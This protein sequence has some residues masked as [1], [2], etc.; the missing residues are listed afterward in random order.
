[1][2]RSHFGLKITLLVLALLSPYV[3]P[4]NLAP[5]VANAAPALTQVT[6]GTVTGFPHQGDTW[7]TTWS[8][9]GNLYTTTDDGNGFGNCQSNV[10]VNRLTG[11]SPSNLTG[12]SVNCMSDY[13]HV[14]DGQQHCDGPGA[15]GQCVGRTWKVGGITS[16]SNVLYLSITRDANMDSYSPPQRQDSQNATIIKSTDHGVTWSGSDTN[17]FNNP[18]FPGHNHFSKPVFIEYGQNGT[19]TADGADTYVYAISNDGYW[20]NGS[21]MYLGRVLR[22]KI[23][24][25]NGADWEFY[26][27]N[28]AWSSSVDQAQAIL[29]SS[30]QLGQAAVN[31]IKP[32]GLYVMQSWYYPVCCNDPSQTPTTIWNFYYAPAP[33]GPW[34]HMSSPTFN[35]QGYYNPVIVSKFTSNDGRHV[36]A[37][38]AGDYLS[39]D[40]EL[41]RLHA[42]DLQLIPDWSAVLTGRQVAFANVDSTS[43]ARL[44]LVLAGA[45]RIDVQSST[46]STFGS[47]G[48]WIDGPFLGQYGRFFADV[49]GDGLADAIVSNDFGV[50]VRR[51]DGT[52]FLP[53]DPNWNDGPF[54]GKYGLFFADVTGGSPRRADAIVSNDFGITVRRSDGTKFLPNETWTTEAFTGTHGLFFADVNGDGKDDAIVSNDFGVTVRR[55]DG[56]KFLPNDP[57]WID[58]PFLGT[59]GLFFADV[60]GDGKADAIVSNDFG[61]TVR[62]SD[63]TKFLPNDPNWIDGPFLGKYGTFFADITGDGKADAIVVN[64][65]GITV[66]R[67]T[68]TS[69][70]SEESW[71]LGL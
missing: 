46:G 6:V 55:S 35:P 27:G 5:R 52:K 36:T 66:R 32:L 14:H 29:T 38:A 11:S 39:L 69:F 3:A 34:T 68:G 20:N 23:G 54:T 67:S 56:T 53:N 60:T 28:G 50:T 15:P 44:D 2:L 4:G 59:Y 62:R 9:D 7:S 48:R 13:G 18:M 49:T 43:N 8:D 45:D 37:F 51:S 71:Y 19:G 31:Y 58:G 16:I 57:N 47:I 12:A 1:M 25:L 61:V 21:A 41:Y 10:V 30:Q 22:T 63:G 24:A 40:P 64:D 17:S 33:W 65:T 70:G 26:A 42:I